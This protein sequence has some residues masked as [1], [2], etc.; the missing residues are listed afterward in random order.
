[1]SVKTEVIEFGR[2][3]FYEKIDLH[4]SESFRFVVDDWW[5]LN[6]YRWPVRYPNGRRIEVLDWC[7]EH[8]PNGHITNDPG[9]AV[10][11]KDEMIATM[12]KLTFSEGD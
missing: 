9:R 11:F 6:G 7:A 1:M 8:A 12:F 5:T 10:L 4:G 3:G 2:K